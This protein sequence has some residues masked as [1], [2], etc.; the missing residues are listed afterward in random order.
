MGQVKGKESKDLVRRLV[1]VEKRQAEE[2]HLGLTQEEKLHYS[3]RA[4]SFSGQ[5]LHYH[6]PLPS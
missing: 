4:P 6:G 5:I 2:L 3:L 1:S